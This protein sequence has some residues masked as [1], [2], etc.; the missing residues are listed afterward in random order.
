MTSDITGGRGSPARHD[1]IRPK[2]QLLTLNGVYFS[3]AEKLAQGLFSMALRR[4][5][6][7]AGMTVYLSFLLL[8]RSYMAQLFMSLSSSQ[9]TS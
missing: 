5:V 6:F 1:H 3:Y 4:L 7:K 2:A 8:L 9:L